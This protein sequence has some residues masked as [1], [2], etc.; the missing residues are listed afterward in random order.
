MISS[1]LKETIV[2]AVES[3]SQ[4]LSAHLG[5][6]QVAQHLTALEAEVRGLKDKVDEE[7]LILRHGNTDYQDNI[8]QH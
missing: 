4:K 6:P 7:I 5:A 8:V 3:I 2:P 1:Y